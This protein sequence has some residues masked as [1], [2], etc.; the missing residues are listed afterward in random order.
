MELA[1]SV[2]VISGYFGTFAVGPGLG[3]GARDLGQEL[4]ERTTIKKL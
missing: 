4:K 2:R 1:S 3:S